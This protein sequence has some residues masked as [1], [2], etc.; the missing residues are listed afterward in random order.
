[1][2]LNAEGFLSARGRPFSSGEIHIL[3]TQ[4]GIPTAKIYGTSPNPPRWPGG[5]Y[6]VQ[7]AAEV[8]AI[9]PQTVWRM[10]A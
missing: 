5:T 8:L 9:T 4:C 6:S 3:R 10:D 7:G 1:M 2:T